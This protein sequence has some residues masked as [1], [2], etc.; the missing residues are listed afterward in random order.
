MLEAGISLNSI[1][2]LEQI[3]RTLLPCLEKRS[4]ILK[5]TYSRKSLRKKG[6]KQSWKAVYSCSI[7]RWTSVIVNMEISANGWVKASRSRYLQDHHQS[8]TENW[9]FV[10]RE[11]RWIMLSRRSWLDVKWTNRFQ[12]S[13]YMLL[14]E[15]LAEKSHVWSKEESAQQERER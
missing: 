9:R 3:I 13:T 6:R 4:L 2:V 8:A 14:I 15:L 7:A 11:F 5:L 12:L 10:M 1:K